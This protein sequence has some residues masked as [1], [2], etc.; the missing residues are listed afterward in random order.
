M[1]SSIVEGQTFERELSSLE[2]IRDSFPK[3]V[4]TRDSLLWGTTATGIE[5]T[6]LIDWLCSE[7]A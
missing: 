7:G 3:I 2:A 4:L 6:S 5:V 1:S